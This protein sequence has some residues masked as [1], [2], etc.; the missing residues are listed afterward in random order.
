MSWIRNT[1]ENTRMR[2]F[3]PATDSVERAQSSY[4]DLQ[5]SNLIIHPTYLPTDFVKDML[6]N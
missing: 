5:L 2:G 4:T 6:I 3:P 1:G